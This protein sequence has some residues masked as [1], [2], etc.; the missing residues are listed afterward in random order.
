MYGGE[1]GLNYTQSTQVIKKVLS[2]EVMYNGRPKEW[3][4]VNVKSEHL[5]QVNVMQLMG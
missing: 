4:E 2:E 5:C 3:V 1:G